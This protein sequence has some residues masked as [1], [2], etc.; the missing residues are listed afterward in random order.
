MSPEEVLPLWAA[1]SQRMGEI[2]GDWME[3]SK[4]DSKDPQGPTF[5]MT[6]ICPVV[7]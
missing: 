2:F 7:A 3:E 6:L 1:A 4:A 5:V